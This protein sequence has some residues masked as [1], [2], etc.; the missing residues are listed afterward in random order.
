M[1]GTV[2]AGRA[3]MRAESVGSRSPALGSSARVVPQVRVPGVHRR[4]LPKP[5]LGCV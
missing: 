4:R 5:L 2:P 1:V 3:S